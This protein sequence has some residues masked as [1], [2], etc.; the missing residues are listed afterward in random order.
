MIAGKECEGSKRESTIL[1]RI[2]IRNFVINPY[3]INH[4]IYPKKCSNSCRAGIQISGLVA[5]HHFS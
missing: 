5:P 4:V 1:H 2:I 3:S